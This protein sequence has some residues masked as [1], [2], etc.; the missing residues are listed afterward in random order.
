MWQRI[1]GRP[2]PRRFRLYQFCEHY[3]R[4]K[5]S[6]RR[7]NCAKNSL[8]P[9]EKLVY[10]LLRPDPCG[11]S[12]HVPRNPLRRHIFVAT[13]G[14]SNYTYIEA[15]CRQDQAILADGKQPLPE[16]FRRRFRTLLVPDNSKAASGSKARQV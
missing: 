11:L 6:Q 9:D 12:T 3:R 2:W 1:S 15:C 5:G 16:L 7:F 14:A 13:L 8:M 4:W 10:R